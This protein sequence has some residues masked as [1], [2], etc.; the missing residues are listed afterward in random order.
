MVRRW[1]HKSNNIDNVDNITKVNI[2]LRIIS[3]L[4]Q[5]DSLGFF[6]KFFLELFK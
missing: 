1:V 4:I 6:H 3:L 5:S 2:V